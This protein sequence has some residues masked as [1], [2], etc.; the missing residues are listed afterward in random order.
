MSPYG[1]PAAGLARIP[2]RNVEPYGLQVQP[3]EQ[4]P[5]CLVPQERPLSGGQ[6]FSVSAFS[7]SFPQLVLD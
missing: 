6:R 7:P 4:P 5:G 2:A 3:T 1:L